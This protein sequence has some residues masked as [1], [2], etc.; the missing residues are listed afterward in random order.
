MGR[1]GFLEGT[2]G[3]LEGRGLICKWSTLYKSALGGI[4]SFKDSE[5]F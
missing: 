5:I 4:V 1:E 3:S 2:N